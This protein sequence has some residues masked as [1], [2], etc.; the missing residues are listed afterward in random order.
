VTPDECKT[1]GGIANGERAAAIFAKRSVFKKLEEDICT[2]ILGGTPGGQFD[3]AK[4]L[5]Q[6]Q[7]AADAL[8]R[9]EGR[10]SLVSSTMTIKRM[11]QQ[12]L[13]DSRL[14]PVFARTISGTSNVTAVQGLNFHAW[15]NALALFL[16]VDEVLA[17]DSSIWNASAVQGRYAFAKLDDGT[18]AL[19]HK[20][21]PV[22]GKVFQFGPDGAQPW[23]VETIGDRNVKNN[24]ADASMWYDI[25]ILNSGAVSLYD[26]VA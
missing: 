3:A 11:V 26:G 4:L 15:Q 24:H 14:A 20:W 25:V 13:G 12:I 22:L 17:G 8:R 9:Y 2:E 16:G 6:A 7:T 5:E 10:Y 21:K 19:A 18:D 1:M 23:Y